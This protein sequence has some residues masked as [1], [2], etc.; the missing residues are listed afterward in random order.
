MRTDYALYAVALI[1]F[2]VAVYAAVSVDQLYVYTL[3]VV[4]IVFVGLGYM[5]RPKAI[6]PS[7]V[8]PPPPPPTSAT[9][10]QTKAAPMI[11]TTEVKEEPKP[12]PVRRASRK[13]RRRRKTA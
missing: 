3:A 6:A 11:E 9:P 2:I 4:G 8:S 1:C 7:T 10:P 13:T 5:A 12:E